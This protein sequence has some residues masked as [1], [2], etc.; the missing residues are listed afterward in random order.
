[1]KKNY[2]MVQAEKIKFGSENFIG[3]IE[4][5]STKHLKAKGAGAQNLQNPFNYVSLNLRRPPRSFRFM[6]LES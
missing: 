4:A 1:M 2:Y 5:K 3:S 6:D